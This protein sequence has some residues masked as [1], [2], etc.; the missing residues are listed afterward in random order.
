[1]PAWMEEML[2]GPAFAVGNAVWNF[3]MGL[4]K[5][6][7]TTTPQNF[8]LDAWDYTKTL[9]T[10]SLGIGLALLNL[11]FLIGFFRQAS[12]LRENITWEILIEQLIKAI[13]ANALMV[14]ELALVREFFQVASSLVGVVLIDTPSFATENLDLG[15]WLFFFIFGAIYVI[16]AVACAFL[17]L[18][19]VYG[20]FL[21]LY[22]MT[23]LAPVALATLAGGRGFE[24]TAYAWI[25]TFLCNVFEIFVIALVMGIGG[26]LIGSIDLWTVTEGVLSTLDGFL[27][28]LHSLFQM[29]LMTG[30]VKGAESMLRRAF[31]L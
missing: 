15:S 2:Q 21:K 7:I 8:S 22:V 20:R 11:F 9:Y 1:M 28:V 23:V 19:A 13:M 17:I 5:G 24:N 27:S 26:K 25:K 14:S 18:F 16:V 29:I 31:G 4:V 3:V 30:A 6:V 12:N 10:W